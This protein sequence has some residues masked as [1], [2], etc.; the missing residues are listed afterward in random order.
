MLHVTET[1]FNVF[2]FFITVYQSLKI[3]LC[4]FHMK[5]FLPLRVCLINTV[6]V[7][8]ITSPVSDTNVIS[9]WRWK[10]C[11]FIPTSTCSSSATWQ[12]NLVVKDFFCFMLIHISH[13]IKY[14]FLKKIYDVINKVYTFKFEN[15]TICIAFPLPSMEMGTKFHVFQSDLAPKRTWWP[16]FFIA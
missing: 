14:Q 1:S 10:L 15:L 12:T 8:L 16:I 6:I 2:Y 4:S 11:K 5:T 9:K 7:C 3:N 13:D